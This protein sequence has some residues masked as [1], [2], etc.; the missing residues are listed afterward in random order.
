VGLEVTAAQ[1]DAMVT[2]APPESWYDSELDREYIKRIL[3]EGASDNGTFGL[4][5]HWFQVADA[6]RRLRGY[7]RA[8]APTPQRLF[9][10]AFPDLTYISLKRRDKIA[11]AVSWY[12]A[13]KTGEYAKLRGAA[14]GGAEKHAEL[15]FDY[16]RIKT[17]WTA[18]RKIY[19]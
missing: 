13:I 15:V 11:Q 8:D 4:T 14:P 9:Q 7:L 6:A 18:L 2:E 12:K 19:E 10:L 1:L 17:Y 5:L 16:A 3:A